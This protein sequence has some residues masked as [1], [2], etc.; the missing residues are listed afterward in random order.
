MKYLMVEVNEGLCWVEEQKRE[1]RNFE[2][3][4]GVVLNLVLG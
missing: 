2:K 1:S 3:K 4:L